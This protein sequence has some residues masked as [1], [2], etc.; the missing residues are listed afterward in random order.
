MPMTPE[1]YIEKRVQNEIDWYDR[2]SVS[3]QKT[4]RRLW[5][6]E[7]VAAALIP[8]LSGLLISIPQ[9]QV[10]GTVIVGALGVT[11]TINAGILGFGRHREQWLEYRTTC[12]SLKKENFLFQTQVEPYTG[13]DA[14]QLFVQR[15][16]ALVSNEHT[17]WAQYMI[18][19]EHEKPHDKA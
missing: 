12:E 6:V 16:E 4:F 5:M 7:I 15:V 8:F 9:F 19:H 3:N 1:E 17:N 14:F 10:V 2:K 13:E 11:V 18:S